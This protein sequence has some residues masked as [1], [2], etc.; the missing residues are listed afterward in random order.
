M[1]LCKAINTLYGCEANIVFTLKIESVPKNIIFGLKMM[2]KSGPEKIILKF[3]H[4]GTYFPLLYKIPKITNS[5]TK[6]TIFP[7]RGISKYIFLDHFHHHFQA[8]NYILGYRF[9][10]EGKNDGCFTAIQRVKKTN[11]QYILLTIQIKIKANFFGI[12]NLIDQV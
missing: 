11:E 3:L 5:V 10:F 7:H 4:V 1:H 8:K 6:I 2:V 12:S 9:H